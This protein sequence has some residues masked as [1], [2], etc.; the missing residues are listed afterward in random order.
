[1]LMMVAEPGPYPQ[2]QKIDW[3]STTLYW[4]MKEFRHKILELMKYISMKIH[5]SLESLNIVGD[6]F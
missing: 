1:M 3:R 4:M 2:S 6:Q 5:N